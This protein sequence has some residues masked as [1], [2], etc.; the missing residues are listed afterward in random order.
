GEWTRCNRSMVA[1]EDL[2]HLQEPTVDPAFFRR[3]ADLEILLSEKFGL[4]NHVD[5][6]AVGDGARHRSTAGHDAAGTAPQLDTSA[7]AGRGHAEISGRDSGAPRGA[8]WAAG[9]AGRFADRGS[10][11]DYRGCLL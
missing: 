2:L 11:C 5:L 3:V 10:G 1:P 8:G 9:G 7:D 4:A 6:D